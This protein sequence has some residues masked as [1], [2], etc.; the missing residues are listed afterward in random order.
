MIQVQVLSEKTEIEKILP[1]CIQLAQ[2]SG[3][4]LPFQY[5]HMPL[6]WWDLF[7]N[8]DGADFNKKRGTNFLGSQSQLQ[9][10]SLLVAWE[11]QHIVGAIPIV[12]YS[13]KM[14]GIENRMRIFTFPGDYQLIAYN[15]FIVTQGKR[16]DVIKS[17]FD[18]LIGL[19]KN[20]SDLIILS[21]LLED[22]PNVHELTQYINKL[23]VK[24]FHCTSAVT[25]RRGGIRPWT[26][27][28]ILSCLRQFS[29]K[30]K[31]QTQHDQITR[32]I[33]ELEA[34]PSM[35]LLFPKTRKI[36]EDKAYW[37]IDIIKDN[38][39]LGDL[40]EQLEAL[41]LD[42]PILYPYISLP[43]DPESYMMTMSKE[44]RRYFRRYKREFEAQGGRFEKIPS[45][46]LTEQDIED[47]LSLHNLRWGNLSV[48]LRND[49]T[50]H[51]HK[52]LCQILSIEGFLTLFFA[53]YQNKRVATHSC[54]DIQGRREGYVTGRDPTYEET[55]ASRLLYLETITD[56]IE[57]GFHMY[58][59]GHGWFAYKMSFTKTSNRTLN[60]FISLNTHIIDLAKIYLGYECMIPYS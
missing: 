40:V 31:I 17:L 41:L 11:E 15:D 29:N 52:N 27:E 58:D 7:N 12:S 25:G 47:Y 16:T 23:S 26:V 42:A 54:I 34:C 3:C 18:A 24:C 6:I 8:T 37:F 35:N 28:S 36:L 22:S 57:N 9:C 49:T 51:F 20:D 43:T 21:Y 30:I 10:M 46:Q 60:F 33:D 32:L 5:L 53:Y 4:K 59:L 45:S 38:P 13:V 44:T 14:P 39:E 48:S 50:Y 2:D 1:Q 19:I 55:R 56:A